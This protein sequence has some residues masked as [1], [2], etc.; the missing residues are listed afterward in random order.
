ML[1]DSGL[2]LCSDNPAMLDYLVF[3][4][5]ETD[6]GTCSWDALAS[7]GPAHSQRLLD[8]ASALLQHLRDRYGPPGPLDEGHAWD[9]DLQ[10]HDEQQQAWPCVWS[11][12]GLHWLGP[13]APG[14]RLTLAL[15]LC[16]SAQLQPAFEALLSG[17][18]RG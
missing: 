8:E 3:D 10:V 1:Y 11:A 15:S 17:E 14:T 7:P 18:H 6:D 9:V 13:P 5:S 2:S 12:A 4:G 16:T